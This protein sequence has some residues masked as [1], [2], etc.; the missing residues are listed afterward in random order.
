MKEPDPAGRDTRRPFWRR[1]LYHLLSGLII[2]LP[3]LMNQAPLFYS[4][5]GTY[6]RFSFDLEPAIDRPIGYSLIIRAVTWQASMW[7]VVFFQGAVASWLIMAVLRQ[8]FPHAQR[9]WRPHLA[10]LAVLTFMSSLPWYASQVMP[11]VLAGFLG[12]MLFIVFFGRRVNR[13]MLALIWVLMFFFTIAHYSFMAMMAVMILFLLALRATRWGRRVMGVNFWRNWLGLVAM[14]T[15]AFLYLMNLND[16]YDRGA[17]LSPTSS[18]FI[19]GKLC[20]SGVMY[21]HLHRVCKEQHRPICDRLEDFDRP[22][23]HYVWDEGAPVREHYD[24]IEAST[25]ADTLVSE[26]LSDPR[27]WGML[28]WTTLH[29][30]LVQLAQIDVGAGLDQYRENSGPWYVY[31]AHL[32]QELPLYMNSLQ[33]RGLLPIHTVNTI[34]T[35]ALYIAM[36]VVIFLW[37]SRSTRWKAFA[38]LVIGIIVVN[39]LCTGA[40]ANVYDRLQARVTWL[41]VLLALLLL[42]REQRTLVSRLRGFLRSSE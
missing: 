41:L 16:R 39:A 34:T 1:L 33:Q 11:D 23:M 42:A 28:A 21:E 24:M 27:N 22:G 2:V 18:L 14:L 8:L 15:A 26:V 13:A 20:E 9:L 10:L 29:A 6:M 7:P 32:P 31:R 4:D 40:M 37:P 35:P 38:L 19:A 25:H 17:V 36:F 3:A 12:I 5:S 30:T